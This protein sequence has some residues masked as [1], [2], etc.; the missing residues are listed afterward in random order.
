MKKTIAYI[1]FSIFIYQTVGYILSFNILKYSIESEFKTK[2]KNNLHDEDCLLFNLNTISKYSSFSW[3]EK[4]KEFWYQGAIY[5]IVSISK[6]GAIKCIEDTKENKLFKNLDQYVDGYYT[7]NLNGRKALQNINNIF[8]SLFLPSKVV[9]IPNRFIVYNESQ[10]DKIA[11]GK[12]TN[13]ISKIVPPPR[14]L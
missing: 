11:I 2:I 7:K 9:E 8:F 10:F 14:F 12:P 5:D 1:L 13:S 3:E 6:S 4:N